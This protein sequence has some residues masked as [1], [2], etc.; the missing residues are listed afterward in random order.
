M[1]Y[2]LTNVI[3]TCFMRIIRST[4]ISAIND[5][6]NQTQ[7]LWQQWMQWRTTNNDNLNHGIHWDQHIR[8]MNAWQNESQEY[9][10]PSKTDAR[11]ICNGLQTVVRTSGMIVC[12]FLW[13]QIVLHA[14]KKYHAAA[15]TRNKEQLRVKVILAWDSLER[16]MH[17]ANYTP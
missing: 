4:N 9:L 7:S 10:S 8:W 13:V 1:T 3:S 11:M 16:D 15:F 5:K 17:S 2:Q 12:T 14:C 6:E